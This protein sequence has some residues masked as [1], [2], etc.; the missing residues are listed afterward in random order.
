MR[1][2]AGHFTFVVRLIQHTTIDVDETARQREGVDVRRVHHVELI[3]E[4]GT[5]G[6]RRQPL[7]DAVDVLLHRRIA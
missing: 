7:S 2:H 6:V 1:K 5:T 4:A 3:L